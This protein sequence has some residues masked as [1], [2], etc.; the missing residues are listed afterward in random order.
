[1]RPSTPGPAPLLQRAGQLS[2]AALVQ[3]QVE[4]GGYALAAPA[5][6]FSAD[7]RSHRLAGRLGC[8]HRRHVRG[9]RLRSVAAAE[10]TG[11]EA[12][13]LALD[14]AEHFRGVVNV[15]EL[16]LVGP[17]REPLLQQRKMFVVLHSDDSGRGSEVFRRRLC[18]GT[19]TVVA[20]T[21]APRLQ[22][23]DRRRSHRADVV[24]AALQRERSRRRPPRQPHLAGHRVE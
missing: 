19:D 3:R 17:G 1:M 23:P 22:R 5:R 6:R 24:D 13:D 12:H 18:R 21:D 2:Q 14:E 15:P 11:D 10:D 9:G 4:D 7:L 20:G 8:R 16:H